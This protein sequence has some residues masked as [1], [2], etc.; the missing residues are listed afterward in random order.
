MESLCIGPVSVVFVT[1]VNQEFYERQ[2]KYSITSS[3]ELWSEG[4]WTD[5]E[6]LKI[7]LRPFLSPDPGEY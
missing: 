6:G 2:T 1:Y 3:W 4:G 5:F 7:F